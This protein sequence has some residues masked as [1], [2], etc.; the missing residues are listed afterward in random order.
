[1]STKENKILVQRYWEEVWN[2]GNLV[3]IDE[4]FAPP[5]IDGQKYFIS[6]TL[7]AFSDSRVTIEDM[8]AEGDK[9]VVRYSWQAT[10]TSVWDITLSNLA[11]NIAPTSK[12]VWDRGI[13][14][15][16]IADGKI[17][18]NWSEW[19]KLELAQQLGVVP[20]AEGGE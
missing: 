10:H 16:R 20:T 7:Q 2:Q 8:I 1:M 5:L 12:Q 13:A 11:M 19:T 9:V 15:F 3:L 18:E 14:I 6:R 4:F 17:V